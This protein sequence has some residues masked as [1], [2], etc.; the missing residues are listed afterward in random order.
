MFAPVLYLWSLLW[1]GG[2]YV[3]RKGN[4]FIATSFNRVFGNA[5]LAGIDAQK[6]V[7][8]LLLYNLVFSVF[9]FLIAYFI[10]HWFIGHNNS[11]KATVEKSSSA[12]SLINSISICAI[13]S[14][15]ILGANEIN[16]QPFVLYD[17]Q[18]LLVMFAAS[19]VYQRFRFT[20]LEK[21]KWGLFAGFAAA[22]FIYFI[23][24]NEI[25]EIRIVRKIKFGI[26]YSVVL[27]VLFFILDKLRLNFERL[28]TAGI[29]LFFG[30]ACMAV[31]LEL[32]NILN[33]YGISLVSK[34]KPPTM[35]TPAD[36][37]ITF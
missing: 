33:Q 28:K 35:R 1:L 37:Q 24:W 17:A 31:F 29:P 10:I 13:A 26:I 12:L 23:I 20:T 8:V 14:L 7:N 4:I 32:T 18:I 25:P 16:L 15:F 21:F 2:I 9:F 34:I 5:T 3:L 27:L 19:L 30:T 6:R 22:L 36:I 11:E